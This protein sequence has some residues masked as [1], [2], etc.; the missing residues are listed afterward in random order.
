M[1]AKT[2]WRTV[3]DIGVIGNDLAKNNKSGF[4]ALPGGYRCSIGDFIDIGDYGIWWSVTEGNAMGS[5]YRGFG[6]GSDGLGWGGN[7]KSCGLS[8]RLLRD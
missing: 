2:D 1:A 5:Y 6:Y 7:Y 8:I 4:S 3:T